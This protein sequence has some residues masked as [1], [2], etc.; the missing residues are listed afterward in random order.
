MKI[1]LEWLGD[2]LP[3]TVSP[4]QAG[5]ALTHGGFPVENIDAFG[6]DHVLDVEVTSNRGD[7]LSHVGVARELSALLNREHRQVVPKAAESSTP[8]SSVTSVAIEAPELCP[9]YTARVIRNVKVGPSPTWLARRLEA[10]GVRPISNVV[11]VTNYV[12]FE[13]GQPLHAF[14]FDRLGGRRIVVRRARAG[15]KLVTIDGHE[16]ELN[17]DM[18]VIADA[19][20]PVALAGVMGGRDSEVSGATTSVLLESARFDP[21]SVR[22]TARALDLRSDS[23]YRFERGIDPT[24]PERA[25]LRAA[26]LIL[27]IAGGELLGGVVAA[28]ASGYQPK[29]LSLRLGR[30]RQV[31]GVELPAGEVVGAFRRLG[32]APVQQGDKVDVTVPSHRLDVNIEADL[33]EEAARVLG[34]DRVPVRD[35]IAIRVTPPEPSAKATDMVRSTLVAGGYFE[36]V[37]FG[38]V[39]DA[40]AGDFVPPEARAGAPLPRA[41]A[42]VRKKDA[43]LRPSILPGLLEAVRRNEA[44]GTAGA[45]LY[46]IGSTFW[47]RPAGGVEERQRLGLVGSADVR[48]VRGVVEKVLARLDAR[49]PVRVVPDERPGYARG[50]CGRVEWGG[51][52]VGYLGTVTRSAA[53]KLSLRELPAAAEL[54]M[55]PLLAGAQLVPQLSKPPAYPAAPRDLSL[56]LPESVRYEAVESLIRGVNPPAMEEVRYVTTYRGKPLEKGTKSVTVTLMFRSPDRTL[57]GEEVESAVQKVVDAAKQQGWGLR[58]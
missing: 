13:M 51:V 26:Q 5:E 10:V 46:E 19:A 21:L 15:E 6:D 38:F 55:A 54:E 14:D 53:E 57:T 39:N 33:V 4:E 42:S 18:L 30:L 29:K 41:D 34:Y 58:A 31:L 1:S 32:L 9:H 20:R 40:L 27:D 56:V 24:L 49:R 7:L 25:S 12:M 2:H 50:A 8:A 45:R 44:A 43:S 52:A 28:G 22:K 23:S 36:A 35:E 3:G 47:N 11:D 16:R 17:G 48:E 37:T